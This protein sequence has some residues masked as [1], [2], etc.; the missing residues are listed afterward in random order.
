MIAVSNT[1]P[2]ITLA[3]SNYLTNLQN[4][5]ER[6]FIPEAVLNEII[7]KDDVTSDTIRDLIGSGFIQLNKVRNKELVSFINLDVGLG[8]A[9]AIVLSLELKPDYLLIDDYR[10]RI[11]A[12]SKAITLIG[13]LGLVKVFHERSFVDEN[14]EEIYKRLTS[15]DFWINKDLFFQ[16]MKG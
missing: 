11:H 1:S 4:I 14:V 16:V 2:L 9:E 15:V 7:S 5:F 8:E 12:E 3:K 6:I 10:A 13:T